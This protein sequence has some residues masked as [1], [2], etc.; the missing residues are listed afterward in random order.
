MAQQGGAKTGGGA[1]S[2]LSLFEFFK[3]NPE[4]EFSIDG[5]LVKSTEDGE[6]IIIEGFLNS[7][8][9]DLDGDVVLPR[10]F[11]KS[12]DQY[13]RHPSVRREHTATVGLAEKVEFADERGP[14]VRLRITNDA[15]N[16]PTRQMIRKGT[17]RGLS[18]RFK[19]NKGGISLLKSAGKEGRFQI[20]DARLLEI[21]VTDVPKS[22]GG[23]FVVVGDHR[24]TLAKSL[25]GGG[26]EDAMKEMIIMLLKSH[27]IDLKEDA[28]DSEIVGALQKALGNG[29]ASKQAFETIA[30]SVGVSAS[31]TPEEILAAI[32]RQGDGTVSKS[33]LEAEQKRVKELEVENLLLQ[34]KDKIT[35]GKLGFAKSLALMNREMFGTWIAEQETVGGSPNTNAGGGDPAGLEGGSPPTTLDAILKTPESETLRK[36]LGA[37]DEKQLAEFAAIQPHEIMGRLFE[38][39]ISETYHDRMYRMNNEW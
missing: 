39:P 27:G 26:E 21:T 31:A 19:P 12:I 6:D 3:S 11:E 10:A 37:V 17:L 29:G 7:P 36:G 14:F 35:D 1:M 13:M 33:V 30:K 9:T 2:V 34:H 18:A 22:S 24:A 38:Q 32:S 16:E 5:E 20:S 23:H 28:S 8:E 15:P 4:A 25:S